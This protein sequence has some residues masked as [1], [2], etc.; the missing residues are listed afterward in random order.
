MA[1]LNECVAD[2]NERQLD[3]VVG[4]G[5]L[6]DN[7]FS[8]F[9]NVNQQLD[10]LDKK[11]FQVLGNHDLLVNKEDLDKVSGALNLKNSYYT[12]IHK[13]WQF[14]FL[15]GNE[16][17]IHSNNKKTVIQAEKILEELEKN[18][19]PN[20]FD[21]NGGVG[22]KQIKWLT[23]QLNSAE[24]KKLNVVIFCHYP[25]LPYEAHS[26]WDHKSVLETIS[27]YDCVK[28]WINRHNHKGGYAYENGIHFITMQG[29]VD[30]ESEN[31]YSI[32]SFSENEI[33]IEGF[34]REKSRTLNF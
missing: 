27:N 23:K 15:N 12:F 29:M 32:L 14:I 3:F 17:T 5:D 2:F 6:I 21:W 31:S 1:K 13:N 8:N 19:Q 24:N 4:L 20:A 22:S 26:L 10:K 18:G 34:G 11:L 16:L 28:A 30:T 33:K 7:D 9:E 25:L